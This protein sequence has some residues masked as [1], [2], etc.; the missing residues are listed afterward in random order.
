MFEIVLNA[1]NMFQ[2]VIQSN[3][4][5]HKT[6][7]LRKNENIHLYINAKTNK[8]GIIIPIMNGRFKINLYG[9]F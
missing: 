1:K 8:N 5:E 6:K 7:G 9:L 2:I 4:Y 3:I